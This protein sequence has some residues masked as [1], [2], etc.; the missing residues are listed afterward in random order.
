[1][2]V[3]GK[4]VRMSS[5]PVS[6]R[7]RRGWW[8]QGAVAF[9]MTALSAASVRPVAAV[10]EE[11]RVQIPFTFTVNKAVLPPGS[12]RV[13]VDNEAG[14]VELR[15]MGHGAFALG[16]PFDDSRVREAKLVFHRYGDEYVLR[17][18]WTGEGIGRDLPEPRRE[19][20]L[21]SGS[22]AR[23][24]SARYERVELRLL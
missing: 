8:R 2:K 10:S 5:S 15:D 13:D 1:M 24:H 18:V 23:T 7:G 9:T 16:I 22:M 19:K 4:E 3:R 11:L 12:Y 21:A 20:E 14:T 6:V 17:E